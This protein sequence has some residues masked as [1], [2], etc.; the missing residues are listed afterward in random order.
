MAKK[1]PITQDDLDSFHQAVKDVKPL[2][3]QKVSLPS[4]P[5]PKF[6]KKSNEASD[7][8]QDKRPPLFHDVTGIPEVASEEYILYKHSSISNKALRKLRKGQYTIEAVLDLHGMT[9]DE[10]MTAVDDFLH[11]CLR[12]RMRIVLVIHGKGHSSSVPI[13]KNKL[14]Q[15]LRTTDTVLAFCS[16]AP[17]HG[18][19]G[20]MYVLLK[21]TTEEDWS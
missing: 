12:E 1:P 7:P 6:K 21:R 10:A 11:Q 17:H 2:K 13:L 5:A 14:N 16:A 18:S 3:Q 8:F 9:I 19:R 20:A 4:K 15:W